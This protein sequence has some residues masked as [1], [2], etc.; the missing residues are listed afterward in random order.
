MKKNEQGIAI[1]TVLIMTAVLLV[2]LSA[3]TTLTLSELRTSKYSLAS[4]QGFYAAEG[5]LNLRAE[6]VRSKFKDYLRPTGIS[7][8][9]TT[10]C[11]GTNL[12]SG[13]YACLTYNIGNRRV[14]TW[15]NDITKP[16]PKTGKIPENGQVEAGDT[17]AGLNYQQ[18]A[19]RVQSNAYNV[20]TGELEATLYMDFQ[21]RLVPLFQF[22]AFYKDDFE[23]HPGPAMTLSGRVH[24]NADLY[25]NAGNSLDIN[26]KTTAVGEIYR[27]GKDKRI[28]EGTVR[29]SGTSMD[30]NGTSKIADAQL[31]IF[32]GNVV[33]NQ[34]ALTLPPLGSLAPD[35]N[36]KSE[37]W[38]QA[39]L[40]IVVTRQTPFVPGVISALTGLPTLPNFRYEVFNENNTRNGSATD[41]LNNC[42]TAG[43]LPGKNPP[44]KAN[45][46]WD[47]R[48]NAYIALAEVDQKAM[49]D[50]I[51]NSSFTAGDGSRLTVD[52][53]SG[54]GL[55]WNISFA[56]N[57]NAETTRINKAKVAVDPKTGKEINVY[58][59]TNL[60]VVIRNADRLGTSNAAKPSEPQIKGLTIVTNQPMYIQGNFNYDPSAPTV[61][62]PAAIL[63]DAI[64]VLSTA[65]D[66]KSTL[67][68]KASYTTAT[69]TDI[70]A[71]FLSGIDLTTGTNYNGGL[72]NYIR[73][74]EKW[75]GIPFNYKGSFVSL[76]NSFHV[77]GPQSGPGKTTRYDAPN[78][79]WD[80][81]TAFDDANNLPPLTPRFVYLRQLLFARTR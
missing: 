57:N 80:Y 26:G 16:D 27:H 24:T 81:D 51:K 38:S 5:G 63:A 58:E 2:V 45:V 10:P 4:Q 22:A 68:T 30:C 50:C 54:G 77:D 75:T 33:R 25:L 71:A 44:L 78:R 55:V 18:Y 62:K 1:V 13:D 42:I 69:R 72:E 65:L 23:I 47:A 28:C 6:L 37:L 46:L 59:E 20:T 8:S 67:V 76:G 53:A 21:S 9:I 7:P 40:R 43:L 66:G 74:H 64:N 36:P 35:P 79:N 60:G 19:Y 32:N 15:A 11:V 49:M 12:G 17:Y 3:Y 48:E 29:F 34:S 39:D 31:K 70:N 61:K 56:D 41:Q 52:D 73:F 14:V